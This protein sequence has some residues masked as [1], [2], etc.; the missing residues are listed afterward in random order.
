M[1]AIVDREK[2]RSR[3]LVVRV[4][5][6]ELLVGDLIHLLR[7]VAPHAVEAVALEAVIDRDGQMSRTM[8]DDS[9]SQSFGCIRCSTSAHG[10]SSTS[11]S[12]AR[13]PSRIAR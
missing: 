9:E 11:V 13:S 8:P 12:P 2:L 7:Q 4:A 6:L 3:E 5:T 1:D 10:G